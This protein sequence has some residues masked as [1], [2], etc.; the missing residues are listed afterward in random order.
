MTITP[1]PAR[2]VIYIS[3]N[4]DGIVGG[5]PFNDEDIIAY[6]T[7]TG[8]WSMYFDGSDVGITGDVNAF[9]LM[10]DG[11]ILLSL[12][13]ATTL[14]N[15]GAVDD[16]DIIRFI[17]SSLGSDT[18]GIFSM[19]LIGANVGL[20]TNNEDIDGIDFTPDGRL[21]VS[22]ISSFSVPGAS[23]NGED[24]IVFN[25]SD[26]SW[27]L[28]FDG[29]DVGL[30]GTPENINGV[31][32]ESTT[33]QLF[34]TTSGTFAVPGVSGAGSDIF[35]CIPSSLGNTTS[36]TFNSYWTGVQYGLSGH[37]LDGI[38]IVR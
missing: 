28:Y 30:N 20:S 25:I 4:I 35:I 7:S 24:L 2:D 14:P 15:L 5:L 18:S 37:I 8:V 29:S 26:N 27:S 6:D 17:P 3:S 16:S 32:I 9:Y 38:H 1:T 22:T 13:T 33:G 23:G 11:S 31:W 34:L 19:Y 36:C 21:V 10:P 12:E